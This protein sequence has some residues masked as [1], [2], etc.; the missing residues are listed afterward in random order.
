MRPKP[1]PPKKGVTVEHSTVSQMTSHLCSKLLWCSE[2]FQ[3]ARVISFVVD[4]KATS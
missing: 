1:E 3:M 2:E 4:A